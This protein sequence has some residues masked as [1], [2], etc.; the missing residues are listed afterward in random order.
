MFCISS[1]GSQSYDATV[2]RS[3]IRRARST[4][5]AGERTAR[6]GERLQFRIGNDRL[7]DTGGDHM[8]EHRLDDQPVAAE[9]VFEICLANVSWLPGD[10]SLRAKMSGSAASSIEGEL[11][12]MTVPERI[13]CLTEETVETLYLLGEQDRIVGITGPS[14]RPR[15][16]ATNPG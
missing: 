15:R 5:D 11:P 3:S 7:L 8:R 12:P 4:G 14:A 13:I 2:I 10:L 16:G 9:D 6:M 1:S